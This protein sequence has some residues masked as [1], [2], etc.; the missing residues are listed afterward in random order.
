MRAQKRRND[1]HTLV[2]VIVQTAH[3]TELQQLGFL[4]QAVAALALNGG[5]SIVLICFKNAS[6]LARSWIKLHSRVASPY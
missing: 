1:V 6:C 2:L 5:N 3:H 4:V